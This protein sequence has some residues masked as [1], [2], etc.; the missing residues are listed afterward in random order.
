MPSLPTDADDGRLAALAKYDILDTSRELAFD[1]ITSLV[2]RIFGVPMSTITFIDG[3]R[4]WFKAS[5]GMADRETDRSPA[6]CNYAIQQSTP[7]VIEDTRLD[8]RFRENTFVLGKPFIRF[9]AGV[10][11]TAEGVNIGTLCAMDTVPRPFSPEQLSILADLAGIVMD[12][13]ELRNV[14]MCDSLTGVLS[15]RAF[16]SEADRIVTLAHRHGHKVT[17]AVLDVDHFKAVNDTY[18]H[19]VGD[20][21]LAGIM[22]T[23][24]RRLRKSDVIGRI[25][26]EEFAVLL[27]HTDLGAAMEVIEKVRQAV[28][29]SSIATPCGP[30]RAT[31][32][33]GIAARGDARHDIDELL[34]CADSAMYL[35]KKAGRNR[36]MLWAESPRI[37]GIVRRRVLKA[38]Q[39]AFNAGRSTM[40]C[41]V[42]ALSDRDATI[43]VISTADL[44]AKFKLNIV[45]DTLSRA[46]RIVSKSDTRLEVEFA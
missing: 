36:A 43:E 22:D 2:R 13:L 5:E 24:R 12:E 21:V 42:R 28:A 23:C 34:R 35:A 37:N 33:F 18:G 3:H 46:C 14:A 10:Q 19:G 38:G 44:P 7:M 41:T 11:L 4:Q 9:Y 29:A 16:R 25:G 39:I 30:I 45:A 8:P 6:L 26:G 20:L 15:R 31:C 32:S 40:D 27:P 1:R 17:C